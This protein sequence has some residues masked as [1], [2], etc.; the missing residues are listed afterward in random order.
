MYRCL[1]FSVIRRGEVS[2]V[3]ARFFGLPWAS[4]SLSWPALT[5]LEISSPASK[6][7]VSSFWTLMFAYKASRSWRRGRRRRWKE[8]KINMLSL[9]LSLYMHTWQLTTWVNLKLLKIK[10][11]VPVAFAITFSQRK[12]YAIRAPE[13]N[14]VGL[15]FL[16]LFQKIQ[17]PTPKCQT[18]IRCFDFSYSFNMIWW[19]IYFILE[20]WG[21]GHVCILKT[22]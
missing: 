11:H 3:G 8:E 21:K 17:R 6:S 13:N 1:T 14:E 15:I 10:H 18:L 5:W 16:L 22:S 9:S 19:F 20:N 4:I 2:D 7:T 12:S